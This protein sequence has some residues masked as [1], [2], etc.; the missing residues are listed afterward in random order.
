MT[1]ELKHCRPLFP[2]KPLW[3]RVPTRDADGRPLFDFMMLIPKLRSAPEQRRQEVL[4]ALQ[5]VFEGFGEE[6]V[7]ADLNLKMNLLWVSLK[8]RKG[9]CLELAEAV[10]ARVPEAVLVA[11]KAEALMG[12]RHTSWSRR[13]TQRLL[14]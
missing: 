3:Q 6:V 14:K 5:Q 1:H 9:A 13:L 10:I 7:F 2:G 11:N 8:P 4:E 12:A